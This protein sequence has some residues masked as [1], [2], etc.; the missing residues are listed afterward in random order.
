MAKHSKSFLFCF[1]VPLCC[2]LASATPVVVTVTNAS[3][4]VIAGASVSRLIGTGLGDRDGSQRTRQIAV[5][6]TDAHGQFQLDSDPAERSAFLVRAVGKAPQTFGFWGCVPPTYH[7]SMNDASKSMRGCVIDSA[8]KPAANI[9]VHLRFGNRFLL[10]PVQQYTGLTISFDLDTATDAQGRFTLAEPPAYVCYEVATDVDGSR[11][12][13]LSHPDGSGQGM[14]ETAELLDG[15][16]TGH[17][18]PTPIPNPKPMPP[19]ATQPTL[20]ISLRVLDSESNL[21]VKHVTVAPGGAISPDQFLYTFDSNSIEL[22]GD[23]IKWSFYDGPWSYFLRVSADGY[24]TT[25]TRTIKASEKN[26]AVELKLKNAQFT[27]LKVLNPDGNPA[28]GALVYLATPT[29]LLDVPLGDPKPYSGKPVATVGAEGNLHFC[30]PAGAYRLA[31][32]G[33]G[34]SAEVD[35]TADKTKPITLT[36]WAS[37]TVIAG[38]PDKPMGGLTLQTQTGYSQD[39]DCSINWQGYYKTDQAGHLTIAKCRAGSFFTFVSLPP[40]ITDQGYSRFEFQCNLKP[41]EHAS[42][43]LMTGTTTVK[44][45]VKDY[46][47]YQW[48]MITIKPCGPAVDL[49]K[50][51][52]Q[53]QGRRRAWAVDEAMA[54]APDPNAKDGLMRYLYIDH[55]DH[56]AFAITG[57]RPGTY[58][59]EGIASPVQT[60]E[61]KSPADN[62]PAA[63]SLGWYFTVPTAQPPFVDLGTL[64]ATPSGSAPLLQPGQI[65]PNLSMKSLDDKPFDLKSDRGHWVLLE[66]WGTWC[67]SCVAEEP[68]LKEVYQGWGQDGRLIMVSASVNDTAEQDRKFIAEKQIPWT[69][70]VLGP[71]GKTDIPEQFGVPYYPTIMLISPE[72]KLVESDLRGAH[73]EEVLRNKLGEPAAPAGGN[74]GH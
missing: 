48:K 5:G 68:T 61:G 47:G 33:E 22:R 12:L 28:A 2:A 23:F 57:L 63:P 16:F 42:W 67:G 56:G 69:Q 71:G 31:I 25:P 21:P 39:S 7:V 60:P 20:T 40:T 73:L 74:A 29:E 65:V 72:G 70:L 4:D 1:L 51:I 18:S 62:P 38:P 43:P 9:T 59:L 11:H 44:G 32:C 49:P 36:P 10:V 45:L 50:G 35:G 27:T 3:G 53:L 24:E 52:N 66:F 55:L 13:V 17:V 19:P 8:G 15:T 46:P 64:S 41:G 37:G 34:G 14:I 26:V 6:K 58:V 54:T 30:P